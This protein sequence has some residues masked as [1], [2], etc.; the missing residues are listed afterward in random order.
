VTKVPQSF[1]ATA[2]QESAD[3]EGLETPDSPPLAYVDPQRTKTNVPGAPDAVWVCL[4]ARSPEDA[5]DRS[6]QRNYS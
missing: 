2:E 4:V 6:V 1:H 3:D 5:T